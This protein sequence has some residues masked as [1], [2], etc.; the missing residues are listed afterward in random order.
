MVGLEP[1]NDGVKVRCLTAWL[2]PYEKKVVKKGIETD[3]LFFMGWIMGLEP[4]TPGTTIRCS[5]N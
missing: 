1:T 5:T 4:T 3:S 2:H